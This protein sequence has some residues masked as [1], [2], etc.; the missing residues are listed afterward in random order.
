L[1]FSRFGHLTKHGDLS[2]CALRTFDTELT[3]N[4]LVI[5]IGDGP[6]IEQGTHKLPLA[7]GG[8]YAKIY[9]IQPET[10][11]DASKKLVTT[12]E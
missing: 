7:G 4:I 1:C 3:D 10:F 12:S 5:Y 9:E 6:V 11:S 2:I 8:E